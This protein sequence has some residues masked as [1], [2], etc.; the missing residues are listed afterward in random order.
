MRK[1]CSRCKE[2]KERDLFHNHKSHKDGKH[3]YCK[4]CNAANIRAWR[5][6]NPERNT[7]TNRAWQKENA[8]KAA[9]QRRFNNY[10][11]SAE[12]IN[13]KLEEQDN[14]CQICKNDISSKFCVDHSHQCCPGKKSCGK[15]IRGLLCQLCNR[16]LGNFHDSTETLQSAINYLDKW[17]QIQY[18]N[19]SNS[20]SE[21]LC[22][23]QN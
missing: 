21:D 5:E 10:K 8:E 4:S 7:A 20:E 15:C 1:R 17:N 12:A 19:K 18:T 11:L 3:C 22:N 16:A 13:T 14:K 9:A 6:A 23:S 2:Y